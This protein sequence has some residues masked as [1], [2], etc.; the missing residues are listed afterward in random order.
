MATVSYG[1][2]IKNRSHA[3]DKTL[4]IYRAAVFYHKIGRIPPI[5]LRWRDE[6]RYNDI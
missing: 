3:F 1:V 5:P 2:K 6:C 4:E